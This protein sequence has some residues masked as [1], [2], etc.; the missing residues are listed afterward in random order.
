MGAYLGEWSSII[1]MF[2]DHAKGISVW[3]PVPDMCMALNG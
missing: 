2:F 3:V 1:R